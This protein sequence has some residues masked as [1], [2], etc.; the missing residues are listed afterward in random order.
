M[1][2]PIPGAADE[3]KIVGNIRQARLLR[4][5]SLEQLAKH[6]GLTKGYLS[7]IENAER[8]PLFSTLM[9]IASALDIAVTGFSTSGGDNDR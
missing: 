6:T 4:E 5:T 1:V 2:D 8:I 9:K 3:R 7:K